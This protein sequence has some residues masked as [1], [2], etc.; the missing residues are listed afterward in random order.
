M[1]VFLCVYKCVLACVCVCVLGGRGGG[2][3]CVRD[4]EIRGRVGER[5]SQR[6]D[7]PG[8]FQ[9]EGI[10][11]LWAPLPIG[12]CSSSTGEQVVCH[13]GHTS[14]ERSSAE[15]S[16]AHTHSHFRAH[17]LTHTHVHTQYTFVER[18]QDAEACEQLLHAPLCLP[19]LCLWMCGACGCVGVWSHRQGSAGTPVLVEQSADSSCVEFRL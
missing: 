4:D 16:Y 2:R 5:A 17:M 12:R 7:S 10:S 1:C 14:Q 8:C 6:R 9:R 13:Q 11:V 3:G 15:H 18:S 19:R